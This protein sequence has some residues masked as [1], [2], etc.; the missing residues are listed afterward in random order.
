MN[1]L[2]ASHADKVRELSALWQQKLDE[3]R[4]LVSRDAPKAARQTPTT[5]QAMPEPD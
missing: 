5:N 2:A 1:D 4:E 3:F